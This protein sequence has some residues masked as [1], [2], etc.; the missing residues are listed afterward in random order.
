MAPDMQSFLDQRSS[1]VSALDQLLTHIP[2][3]EG[4]ESTHTDW[5]RITKSLTDEKARLNSL[6]PSGTSQDTEKVACLGDKIDVISSHI[7]K[8]IE[9]LESF[10]ASF[11]ADSLL[12]IGT[13]IALLSFAGLEEPFSDD[14]DQRAQELEHK[15]NSSS[16]VENR[17]SNLWEALTSSVSG[18]SCRHC[19]GQR[20]LCG[21]GESTTQ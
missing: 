6:L 8:M 11:T 20:I 2:R 21:K 19:K 9:E 15:F 16:G 4:T 18:C 3:I 7:S 12:I 14:S 10:N 17:L 5:L 1:I 13:Q